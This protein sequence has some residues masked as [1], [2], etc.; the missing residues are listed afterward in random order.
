MEPVAGIGSLRHEIEMP[1]AARPG[2]RLTL[3]MTCVDR[4]ESATRPD[5]GLLTFDGVLANQH[6]LPVLKLRSLMM[7]R[8]RPTVASPA[9]EE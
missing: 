6:G 4:R 3:T 8:R 2:D 7:V 5:R 1:N 9:S